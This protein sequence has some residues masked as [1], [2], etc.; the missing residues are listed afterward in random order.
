[1]LCCAV[2]HLVF[3]T[4]QNRGS[5][6]LAVYVDD[7]LLTRSDITGI[8]ETKEYPKKQFVTKDMG[9]SIYFLRIEFTHGKEMMALSQRKYALDLLQENM[10]F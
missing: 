4:R 1:M 6:I 2:D 7:I 8:M 9:R 5:V 3:I 10:N